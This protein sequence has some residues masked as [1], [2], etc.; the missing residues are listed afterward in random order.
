MKVIVTDERYKKYVGD[1]APA[2]FEK[3]YDLAVAE[4]KKHCRQL[5]L[6]K[7]DTLTEQQQKLIEKAIM[8]Q[9]E[10]IF[11][12]EDEFINGISGGFSIGKFS[13]NTGNKGT[14]QEFKRLSESAKNMLDDTGI[15]SRWVLGINGCGC[16]G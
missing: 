5:D 4:L 8:L 10:Y 7:F 13:S 14:S 11:N 1:E 3:F 9:I 6:S 15:C 16:N 12:N 2:P